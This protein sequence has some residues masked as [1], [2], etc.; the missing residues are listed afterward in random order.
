[1]FNLSASGFTTKD[2]SAQLVPNNNGSL[3]AIRFTIGI[4]RKSG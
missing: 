1:M 2:A 4:N 3:Y